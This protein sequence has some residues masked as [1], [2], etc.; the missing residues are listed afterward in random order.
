[1]VVKHLSKMESSD[2]RKI[3]RLT[4]NFPDHL[5]TILTIQNLSRLS[6]TFQAIRKLSRYL[7]TFQAIRKLS[8]LS[9]NFLGYLETFWTIR[10]ISGLSGNFPDY[11]ET[12]QTI[13][14]LS[15]LSGNFPGYPKTFQVI[16]TFSGPSGKYPDYPETFW[17]IRKF[18]RRYG[19]FPVQFQG[20]RAKTFRTRKNFPG[21][22]ATLPPRF[23]ASAPAVL[24]II[25]SMSPPNLDCEV[26]FTFSQSALVM[27]RPPLPPP[28]PPVSPPPPGF[29]F[30]FF[31]AIVK[32][33]NG[34]NNYFQKTEM[35]TLAL[36][37]ILSSTYSLKKAL[38]TT[39]AARGKNDVDYIYQ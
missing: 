37:I 31:W 25:S 16:R 19:N 12:F 26:C 36:C 22:N 35:N 15:R 28:P 21:G 32:A 9:G 4:R 10:K 1:M 38:L 3:S 23:L 13:L 24:I 20:L 34:E 5:E 11:P 6:G 29:L 14:K 18:S 27:P 7:E 17:T 8:R 30:L 2:D 33:K 39:F